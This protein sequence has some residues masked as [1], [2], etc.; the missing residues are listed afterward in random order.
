MQRQGDKKIRACGK[1][2]IPSQRLI[3]SLVN[4]NLLFSEK[5]DC[6]ICVDLFKKQTLK[7][8]VVLGDAV[9]QVSF[10]CPYLGQT[11]MNSEKTLNYVIEPVGL[12]LKSWFTYST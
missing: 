9:F 1:D 4:K 11:L 12:S 8:S 7:S 5:E 10:I 2:S 6:F 3:L